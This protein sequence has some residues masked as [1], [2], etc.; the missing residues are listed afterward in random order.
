MSSVLAQIQ[1]HR[2]SL[3][4]LLKDLFSS[5]K[6]RF[7]ASQKKVHIISVFLGGHPAVGAAEIV[8]MMYVHRY[9]EPKAMRISQNRPARE[10]IHEKGK[11]M[12]QGK[13]W[14]WAIK[15]V[16][17]IVYSEAKAMSAKETGFHL[18]K[19]E[20]T[21]ESIQSFSV[22]DFMEVAKEKGPT[23]LRILKATGVLYIRESS[24][25]TTASAH[26]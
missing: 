18:D 7:K 4:S 3:S 20:Q 26:A 11:S 17:G 5:S 10:V 25:G 22:G 14:E 24:P 19:E 16:E 12:A 1:R 6:D 21:W 8:D 13:L 23:H 9:S 15:I 2:W